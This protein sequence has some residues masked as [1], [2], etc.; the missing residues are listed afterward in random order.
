MLDDPCGTR[1]RTSRRSP[2]GRRRRWPGTKRSPSPR[3]A[4][5]CPECRGPAGQ[6]QRRAAWKGSGAN[7]HPSA[8]RENRRRPP[9]RAS[10]TNFR[11][12]APRTS[13]VRRPSSQPGRGSVLRRTQPAPAPM[14]D[15]GAARRENTASPARHARL[16]LHRSGEGRGSQTALP[17]PLVATVDHHGGNAPQAAL[18]GKV[19]RFSRRRGEWFACRGR[20]SR[21]ADPRV[22]RS[23]RVVMGYGALVTQALAGMYLRAAAAITEDGRDHPES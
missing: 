14:L 19:L 18:N 21:G 6:N 20:S 2:W 10:R 11:P 3:F 7:F 4:R 16:V 8:P 13:T 1:P 22:P 5:K 9:W 15:R 23:S 12:A 17:V